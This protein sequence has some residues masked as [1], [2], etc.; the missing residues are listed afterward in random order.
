MSQT[1]GR[2][3]YDLDGSL[4]VNNGKY[5]VKVDGVDAGFDKAVAESAG[6]WIRDNAVYTG[7]AK[8]SS[9]GIV[10]SLDKIGTASWTD[11]STP[12]KKGQNIRIKTD[13][14]TAVYKVTENK[15][16]IL[17]ARGRVPLTVSQKAAVTYQSVVTEMMTA[18][19]DAAEETSDGYCVVFTDGS[20]AVPFIDDTFS[21][22]VTD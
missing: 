14:G 8:G 7:T 12:Y 19:V 4:Y 16:G 3:I 21:M 20:P 11:G 1:D 22:I 13:D 17:T 9:S 2:L 18:G 10:L 6:V 15:S 5:D